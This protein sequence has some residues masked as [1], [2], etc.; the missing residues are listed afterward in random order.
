MSRDLSPEQRR[1]LEEFIRE[2]EETTESLPPSA[3]SRLECAR[4]IAELIL[5]TAGPDG[6]EDDRRALAELLAAESPAPWSW[7]QREP[8]TGYRKWTDDRVPR[9]ANE[10][11]H[12]R[13]TDFAGKAVL[14]WIGCPAVA[15]EV[16]AARPELIALVDPLLMTD[17][18][19]VTFVTAYFLDCVSHYPDGSEWPNPLTGAPPDVMEL[20]ERIQPTFVARLREL[21]ARIEAAGAPLDPND[22]AVL[23]VL[24]QLTLIRV[25]LARPPA[26]IVADLNI[27]PPGFIDR[28]AATLGQVAVHAS[29]HG[30][31]ARFQADLAAGGEAVARRLGP[32]AI[33][34]PYAGG[35][36]RRKP[37][38]ERRR[39]ARIEAV[40]MVLRL[41]PDVTAGR[42]R[43]TWEAGP[44]TPGGLF[45]GSLG[46][47][48]HDPSPCESTLR[49]D[50]RELHR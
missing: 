48:P 21:A 30:R 15:P 41:H 31:N 9:N 20:A 26:E 24:A 36:K 10:L 1:E 19:I 45:R 2:V 18:G 44:S 8:G 13:Q 42:L 22:P 33:R 14:G 40:R 4:K 43:A 38:I 7:V 17:Q 32:P 3:R 25:E 49:A 28:E 6:T 39:A 37:A 16:E 46:L 11:R 12:K 23:L 47:Q 29:R 5:R 50:L 34:G 35:G 27:W